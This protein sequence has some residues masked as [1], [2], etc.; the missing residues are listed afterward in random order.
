[1]V[2]S[3]THI[4]HPPDSVQ[5]FRCFK[6]KHNLGYGKKKHKQR[7]GLFGGAILPVFRRM[8]KK[9]ILSLNVSTSCSISC[10]LRT[11]HMAGC[12]W[13]AF[14]CFTWPTFLLHVCT[15]VCVCARAAAPLCSEGCKC[16]LR[17]ML[18]WLMFFRL[19][20]VVI[21]ISAVETQEC[22]LED[23]LVH[24][25]SKKKKRNK[26]HHK[27]MYAKPLGKHSSAAIFNDGVM[28]IWCGDLFWTH[29]ASQ[30][31]QE[32]MGNLTDKLQNKIL[33]QDILLTTPLPAT[34]YYILE[35]LKT[36]LKQTKKKP[37]KKKK[38][39]AWLQV[40]A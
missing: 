29:P 24:T 21:S 26:Q 35:L 22:S 18:L 23:G 39:L 25:C 37:N 13:N 10:F 9:K 34:C 33:P 16:N 4:L 36:H 7:T 30:L 19:M 28:I 38:N 11:S 3:R 8:L 17:H 27:H 5:A 32:A 14:A 15:R 1:M 31:R 12:L 20:S 2:F 6:V 40:H